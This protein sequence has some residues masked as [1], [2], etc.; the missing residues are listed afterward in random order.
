MHKEPSAHAEQHQQGAG[1]ADLVPTVEGGS[2]VAEFNRMLP[3]WDDHS[4][5][6]VVH[7]QVF[8]RFAVNVGES[9]G[10]VIDF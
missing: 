4:P 1:H 2:L 3:F 7:T 10:C 5:Q 9:V 8:G 6:D